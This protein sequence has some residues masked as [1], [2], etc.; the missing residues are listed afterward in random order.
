MITGSCGCDLPKG[1]N[2]GSRSTTHR[3]LSKWQKDGTLDSLLS[4]L[5]GCADMAGMINWERLAIDGFFS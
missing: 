3:W 5:K 4:A 1:P 2:W